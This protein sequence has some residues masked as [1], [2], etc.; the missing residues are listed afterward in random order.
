[1][2]RLKFTM[3]ILFCFLIPSYLVGQTITSDTS[4]KNNIYIDMS[5]FLLF[6]QISANYERII[7]DTKKVSWYGRLGFGKT[8]LLFDDN[9][10]N[11][12]NNDVLFGITM[13]TGKSNSH[14]EL[15]LG[16]YI[17]QFNDIGYYPIVDV[18]YRYQKRVEGVNFK[19]KVGSLGVGLGL[20]YNF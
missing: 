7:Y 20:G 8:A 5:S 13:L 2:K 11:R 14:F 1:M 15:D 19:V 4:S 18:G 16:S 12:N 9:Y 10:D 17:G 6:S 3:P